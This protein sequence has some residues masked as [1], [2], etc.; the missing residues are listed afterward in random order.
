M[1]GRYVMHVADFAR[2]KLLIIMGTS[3]EADHFHF[4]IGPCFLKLR[5]LIFFPL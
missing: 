4:K 5:F 2:S 1:P 3:L